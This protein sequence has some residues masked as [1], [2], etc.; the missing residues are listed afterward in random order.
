MASLAQFLIGL[1]RSIFHAINSL[2]GKS[3][4]LDWLARLGADDHIIPVALSLLVL[5]ALLLA[6]NGRQRETAFRCVICAVVAAAISMAV[7][8]ALNSLFFRPRPFTSQAVRLLFYHNTD[9]ALPSNAAT[10]AF[11]LA[12]AVVFYKR[13]LGAVMLVLACYVGLART[14][15]GVHYPLDVITGALLGLS[16]ASLAAAMDPLFRPI[17]RRLT[18]GEHRL[19]AAWEPPARTGPETEAR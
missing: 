5:L 15:A 1:D 4:V 10:L 17:A 8:F 13:K 12:F 7:L 3:S 11:A 16:S 14:M 9:S 19:L 6:G 18:G 2:A